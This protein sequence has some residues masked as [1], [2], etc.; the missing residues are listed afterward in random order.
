MPFQTA[1][2]VHPSLQGTSPIRILRI[3]ECC[4]ILGIGRSTYYK[5]AAEGV[6]EPS[7]KISKRARGHTDEY[8][9]ALIKKLGSA[10]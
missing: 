3:N 7:I 4:E 9:Q 6:I 5:L 8:L 2:E 10:K 1:S